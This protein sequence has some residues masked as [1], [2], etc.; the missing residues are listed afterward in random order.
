MLTSHYHIT[1]LLDK[2]TL[3][4]RCAYECKVMWNRTVDCSHAASNFIQVWQALAEWRSEIN[5]CVFVYWSQCTPCSIK[6]GPLCFF[7]K[8]IWNAGHENYMTV[9]CPLGICLTRYNVSPNDRLN[10]LC[11]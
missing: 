9:L 1:H 3:I 8:F 11:K 6:S 4:R 10:I 5:C 2:L 7:F